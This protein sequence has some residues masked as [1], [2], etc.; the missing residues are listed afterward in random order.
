MKRLSFEE[1]LK[2]DIKEYKECKSKWDCENCSKNLCLGIA[3]VAEL[4]S[5]YGNFEIIGFINNKDRKE[6]IAIIKGDV[7]QAENVL[8]RVHSACLTG[9]ALGSKRCDCG[10]QLRTALL[11]IERE[12]LGI[13]LY[14]QQEGRGIGL[15]NKLRA[16]A[17]QDEGLDTYDANTMLGFAPDARDYEVAAAMLKRLDPKSIRLLTNNPEKINQLKQYDINITERVPLESPTYDQSI[18]YM[19]TKKQRFGHMLNHTADE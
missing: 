3:A 16:Y 14:M 5:L 15:I 18:S 2:E 10:P 19:Q 1:I 11:M 8:T 13:V 7:S 9:D 17:L 12:G 6:H 4:P